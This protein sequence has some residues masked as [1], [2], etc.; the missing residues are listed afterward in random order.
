[1]LNEVNQFL[2]DSENGADVTLPLG[3]FKAFMLSNGYSL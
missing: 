1:M 2:K 3:T